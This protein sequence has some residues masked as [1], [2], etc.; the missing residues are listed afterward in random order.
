MNIISKVKEYFKVD[1]KCAELILNLLEEQEELQEQYN[2]LIKISRIQAIGLRRFTQEFLDLIYKYF[3]CE[4]GAII[5][6]IGER[7]DYLAERNFGKWR[8]KKINGQTIEE[9]VCRVFTEEQAIFKKNLVLVPIGL[10]L[11]ELYQVLAVLILIRP[12]KKFDHKE[13][14]ILGKLC[15]VSA[16]LLHFRFVLDQER[17]LSAL[18]YR[19][20]IENEK[21][22]Q[23]PKTL[24]SFLVFR[25][26]S[27]YKGRELWE[28]DIIGISL[29]DLFELI[30]KELLKPKTLKEIENFL[31][32]LKEELNKVNSNLKKLVSHLKERNNKS[33]KKFI[34]KNSIRK[35][36][37]E[38]EFLKG[39]DINFLPMKM[40]GIVPLTEV[41]E[42]LKEI[43]EEIKDVNIDWLNDVEKI[44][45]LIDQINV[46]LFD[47]GLINDNTLCAYTFQKYQ[48]IFSKNKQTTKF[49]KDEGISKKAETFI[50]IIN[51][52][53]EYYGIDIGAK[54]EETLNE[55]ANI[56]PLMYWRIK[57][58]RDHL[59][60]SCRIALLGLWLLDQKVRWDNRCPCPKNCGQKPARKSK[61]S[62]RKIRDY[63]EEL[64]P[65]EI[66]CSITD[67]EKVPTLERASIYDYDRN[68]SY[69]LKGPKKKY[70]IEKIWLLASLKHDIG[71]SFTYLK[72]LYDKV[73]LMQDDP[74]YS[75]NEIRK[76]LDAIFS[77]IFDTVR[78][79]ATSIDSS[80]YDLRSKKIPHGAI[81]A[82]HVRHLMEDEY[83]REMAARAISRHDDDTREVCFAKE[84]L[85]YILIL[86]DELQEWGRPVHTTHETN[87]YDLRVLTQKLF[88]EDELLSIIYKLDNGRL[89]FIIDYG[90]S[91][92]TLKKTGFSFPHFIYYK[93]LN[94]SRLIRGPSIS[95][96]IRLIDLAKKQLEKF[97]EEASKKGH[98]I[99][100]EWA[101]NIL[102]QSNN[103][104]ELVFD[105]GQG[106]VGKLPLE[107]PPEA[108]EPVLNEI[109]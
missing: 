1:D 94:L 89:S 76:Q 5:T 22:K 53:Q 31:K 16:P 74:S 38:T 62:I 92:Q 51:D 66:I 73:K 26:V 54:I 23:D 19:S 13:I 90:P 102:K 58:Y 78:T 103:Q 8:D 100:A 97:H 28:W 20:L 82:F 60:H 39:Y 4:G 105:L 9:Y 7:I 14:N 46:K 30:K 96:H 75:I 52:L 107:R 3:K 47:R 37:E 6:K 50:T 11:A 57:R 21:I 77:K 69:L 80:L 64:L 84:P 41:K 108:V 40:L 33:L 12:L 104:G 67:K 81:G 15:E 70:L 86:L 59:F 88:A 25:L 49:N 79:H 68:Y 2:L 87:Y 95:I 44:I 17:L 93:Q 106:R 65:K 45:D 71:Y 24:G 101:D 18:L 35:L 56:E 61:P 99:A 32:D 42:R 72:E 43:R 91:E 10:F 36:K 83:I 98:T 29:L 63:V 27:L 48:N 55:L 85:S 109:G 34:F